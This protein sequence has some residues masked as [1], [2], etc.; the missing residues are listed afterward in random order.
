MQPSIFTTTRPL[1]NA[2]RL[3]NWLWRITLI[4]GSL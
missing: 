2:E 1:S 3:A 4:R